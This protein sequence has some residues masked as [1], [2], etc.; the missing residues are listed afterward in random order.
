MPPYALSIIIKKVIVHEAA[1]L[2]TIFPLLMTQLTYVTGALYC[3]SVATIAVPLVTH[4]S[5]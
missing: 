2:N 1:A 4:E 5:E 3:K